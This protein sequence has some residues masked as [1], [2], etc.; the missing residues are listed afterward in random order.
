MNSL[1]EKVS[2]NQSGH[3]GFV[4]PAYGV[5]HLLPL[6]DEIAFRPG[7]RLD[8][9]D[10]RMENSSNY[11]INY[12]LTDPVD[13][14][15]HRFEHLFSDASKNGFRCFCCVFEGFEVL[16]V[17]AQCRLL[18]FTRRIREQSRELQVQT[19]IQGSWNRYSLLAQ[20][21]A[22]PNISPVPDQRNI[23][24][25]DGTNIEDLAKVFG[26][27]GWISGQPNELD[28][29]A[30]E[31]I[32]EFTGGDLLLVEEV[33]EI[34]KVQRRSLR[35]FQE[36]AED[37]VTSGHVFDSLS[38]RLSR[39]SPGGEVIL[40]RVL[41]LLT[42]SV[43]ARSPLV[44]E[45]RLLG[46]IRLRKRSDKVVASIPSPL[47][48]RALRLNWH[49]YKPGV[50]NVS[51][52][53]DLNWPLRTI[54]G[55]AYS[56]VM[57]IETLLRNWLVSSLSNQ[58]G[59][60]WKNCIKDVK[61]P[62]SNVGQ[63]TEEILAL[64]S[65]LI[66]ILFPDLDL[67]IAATGSE[68]SVEPEAATA[69]TPCVAKAGKDKNMVGVIDSAYDW[70]RRVV[71]NVFVR[72][73][74]TGLPCFFTTGALV[75]SLMYPKGRVPEVVKQ[76]FNQREELKRFL[77]KFSAIRSAVAHNQVLAFSALEDL[78]SLLR[79]LELRLGTQTSQ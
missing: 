22:N 11:D 66:G 12:E 72:L 49:R 29:R 52:S 60:D 73:A 54:N 43:D 70:K 57:E 23:H 51:A 14:C 19:I 9:I 4:E 40:S 58:H 62:G 71:T 44:E 26:R 46:L 47:L 74:E 33:V 75:G 64:G 77:T 78:E 25:S 38:A 32:L 2:R 36:T 56:L 20:W 7:V 28:H 63:V 8:R 69:E 16:D 50:G 48:E 61:T 31:A 30:I 24:C 17:T 15:C 10:V 5:S 34:L 67:S 3:W 55:Y 13:V 65:Q 59:S 6:I 27:E 53:G 1:I 68:G 21:Q 18:S 37:V 79:E 45:L 76:V 42:L 39:L 41:E 35:N